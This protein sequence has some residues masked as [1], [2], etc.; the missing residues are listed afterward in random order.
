MSER[1]NDS[2]EYNLNLLKQRKAEYVRQLETDPDFVK[3]RRQSSRWPE[4]YEMVKREGI[5][6]AGEDE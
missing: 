5:K 3:E 6:F 1:I 2:I 4:I